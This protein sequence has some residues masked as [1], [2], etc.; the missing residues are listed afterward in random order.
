MHAGFVWGTHD[1][2]HVDICNICPR[3]TCNGN[4]HGETDAAELP[5]AEAV[6]CAAALQS[7]LV[8]LHAAGMLQ[9]S[10]LALVCMMRLST[11][12]CIA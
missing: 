10:H 8:P 1:S 5:G 11:I 2:D 12:L 3:C 9:T 6:E 4:R 7:A